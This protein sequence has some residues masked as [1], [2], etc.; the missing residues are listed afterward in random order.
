MAIPREIA[1][2]LNASQ[3]PSSP[4]PRDH[5]AARGIRYPVRV[6]LTTCGQNV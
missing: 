4:N 5:Q 6:V 3:I 2:T 1:V